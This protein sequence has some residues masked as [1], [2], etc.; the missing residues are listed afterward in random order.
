M[1]LPTVRGPNADCGTGRLARRAA[2]A[3]I[4]ARRSPPR[5]LR[6]V[7]GRPPGAPGADPRGAWRP[8][9]RDDRD[10]AATIALL[11]DAE[12]YPEIEPGLA[13]HTLDWNIAGHDVVIA[14]AAGGTPEEIKAWIT[15]Q[16]AAD[17]EGFARIGEIDG[18]VSRPGATCA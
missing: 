1:S 8:P 5:D 9:L 14:T 15:G 12:V 4:L 2:T 11:I 3:L 10:D 6:R 13:L 16:Y 18:F 7:S 17:C